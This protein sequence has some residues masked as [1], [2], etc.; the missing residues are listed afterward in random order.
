MR[1]TFSQSSGSVSRRATKSRPE[2][3][4]TRSGVDA[5]TV[6]VRGDRE[7]SAISPTKLP[8]AEMRDAATAAADVDLALDHDVELARGLAFADQ[9]RARVELA[10]DGDRGDA[11]QVALG[12]Q[13]E[14]RQ[15]AKQLDPGIGAKQHGAEL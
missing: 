11:P 1:A 13:L 4:S 5:I 6:A 14:Q 3:A 9:L 2:I 7:R 8:V 10:L 12:A 15:A